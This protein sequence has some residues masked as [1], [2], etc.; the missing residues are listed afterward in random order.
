MLS[1]PILNGTL[2]NTVNV[3]NGNVPQS[4]D[5]S[6]NTT[7][8]VYWLAVYTGDSNNN[9]SVSKCGDEPLSITV[10]VPTIQTDL[11][12]GATV[13]VG[14]TVHDTATISNA[15]ADASGTVDY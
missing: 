5:V 2:V 9:G 11:K 8:T 14:T 12:P 6:F 3:T 7:G 10:K 4:N 13:A 1:L 15:T